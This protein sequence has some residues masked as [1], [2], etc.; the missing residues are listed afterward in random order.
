MSIYEDV[1]L[2]HYQNPRN[3]KKI[4]KP[5]AEI[6][7]SNPLCGD[8]LT[9]QIIEK[10]G[11]IDQIGFSGEGCAISTA[12]ASMV[13]EYVLGKTVEQIRTLTKDD[14]LGLV[15]IT[16][17]PNRMK[18]ALLSWEGIRKVVNRE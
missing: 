2:D 18:C 14:V 4:Q 13:S 9:F 1:I 8:K 7:V 6:H 16:L 11:L 5:T 3:Y 12:A 10:D 15:G 17:T